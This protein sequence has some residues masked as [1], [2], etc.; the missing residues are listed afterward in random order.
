MNSK[1]TPINTGS[2]FNVEALDL[3]QS[4]WPKLI[5]KKVIATFRRILKGSLTPKY[6][7]ERNRILKERHQDS[8][9]RLSTEQKHS[10]GLY[11]WIV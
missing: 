10:L 1:T 6:E 8:R 3:K 4:P 5:C 7:M 2:Y 11:P 9:V